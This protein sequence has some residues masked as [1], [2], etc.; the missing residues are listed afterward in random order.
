M[1]KKITDQSLPIQPGLLPSDFSISLEINGLNIGIVGL[2]VTFLQ[3]G[4]GDYSKQLVINTK[5]FNK[6]CGTEERDSSEW[7]NQ[8]QL[9]LLMTHQPPSWLENKSH[10]NHYSEIAPAGR[11]TAHLFGHMHEHLIT[12]ESVGGGSVRRFRQGSSLFGLGQHGE[13]NNKSDRKH[14]YSVHQIEINGEF[15]Y[16]RMW[17]RYANKHSVNG[18]QIIADTKKF[19]D[20]QPD[21]GTTPITVKINNPIISKTRLSSKTKKIHTTSSSVNRN[22]MTNSV[23]NKQQLFNGWAWPHDEPELKDYCEALVKAHRYIRFVEVP[24]LKDT[25]D[26][27]LESLYVDPQFSKREIHAD[28]PPKSW[29]A[30]TD[31]VNAILQHPHLVLL[32]DPGSGKSTLTSCVTWQLCRPKVSNHNDWTNALG[33]F[34][35]IPMVLRELKLKAATP[36][37]SARR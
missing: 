4:P 24:F 27:E 18:W 31:A 25:L 21:E 12:D 35:P 5:Q 16:M 37:G 33:G 29:P 23:K 3:L 20:L 9:C 36:P 14:G 6:A 7:I 32:R 30:R 2:N 26:V 17:P 28:T 11:F 8:H 22:S 1:G 10:E 15:A 13:E 34:V 19:S